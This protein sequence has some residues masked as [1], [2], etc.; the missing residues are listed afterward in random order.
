MSKTK[1]GTRLDPRVSLGDSEVKGTMQ[2][3]AVTAGRLVERNKIRSSGDG[4]DLQN[5]W[6]LPNFYE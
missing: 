4:S 2:K 1:K 6:S 3:L 5:N